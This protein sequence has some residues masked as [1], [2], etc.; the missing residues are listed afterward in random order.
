MPKYLSKDKTV[1]VSGTGSKGEAVGQISFEKGYYSTKDEAE[2][3][4]LD[5]LALLPGSPVSFDQKDKE[6]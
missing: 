1:V 3:A 4:V 6:A 2:I 5:D